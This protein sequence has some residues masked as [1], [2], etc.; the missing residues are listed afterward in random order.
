M[1]VE[2]ASSITDFA[3]GI[4]ALSAALGLG[5]SSGV[6]PNWRWAFLAIGVGGLL[7]G[8]YHGFIVSHETIAEASWS[9][10]SLVIAV[11]ISFILAAT[12]ATVLGEGRGRPLLAIRTACLVA[13][14]ILAIL[15]HATLTTLVITEGLAMIAVL[16]LWAHAWRI[17][18][19]GVGLVIIAIL[20]SM[21]A[22]AV[23][24]SGIHGTFGGWE[25]D[26]DALYHLAQMP[27]LALLY[28]ALRRRAHALGP[29][30]FAVQPSLSPAS[31][32]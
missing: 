10:I 5:K 20:A 28:V 4:V 24:G 3:L 25:F 1:L 22:G 29:G 12:V 23:R 15:G 7:G 8:I 14:L 27:G 6:H 17:G 21:L 9:T 13:F 26:P 32:I 19:P 31:S 30:T 16:V 2:P 11:A 18:Q